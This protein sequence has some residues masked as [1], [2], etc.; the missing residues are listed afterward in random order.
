MEVFLSHFLIGPHVFRIYVEA[1]A[2]WPF[3]LPRRR[4]GWFFGK[5]G[6]IGAEA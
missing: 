2:L 3:S 1:R 6:D 5:P 4:G